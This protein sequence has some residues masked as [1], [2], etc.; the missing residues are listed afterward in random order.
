MHIRS[1]VFKCYRLGATIR[2]D[3]N[4]ALH[5]GMGTA[6]KKE[7]TLFPPTHSSWSSALQTSK[8]SIQAGVKTGPQ[9]VAGTLCAGKTWCPP[10]QSS[11]QYLPSSKMAPIS[12]DNSE[13]CSAS[14]GY[15]A[16]AFRLITLQREH[17]RLEV[18]AKWQK[19]HR[20]LP[21]SQSHLHADSGATPSEEKMA[22]MNIR[23]SQN[24]AFKEMMGFRSKLFLREPSWGGCPFTRFPS[25]PGGLSF[26][27]AQHCGIHK[28]CLLVST[29][30]VHLQREGRE[31]PR[32]PTYDTCS[33]MA[34]WKDQPCLLCL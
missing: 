2:N 6:K 32:E 1:T 12:N 21:I 34:L 18:S 27:T 31:F 20:L 16:R 19:L 5:E 24:L 30:A 3:P 17:R 15:T 8:P 13:L 26:P 22:D 33:S 9:P 23:P 28:A 7:E 11:W 14:H 29:W 25:L 4:E 10:T